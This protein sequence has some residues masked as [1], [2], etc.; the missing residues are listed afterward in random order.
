MS[1]THGEADTE[2]VFS[3]PRF[4]LWHLF[5]LVAWS[6]VA[7][8][9]FK[10]LDA[11]IALTLLVGGTA[12]I[13]SIVARSVQQTVVA[14]GAT[15]LGLML[16]LPELNVSR[17]PSP[18]AQC[19]NNLKQITLALQN[20]EASH[21]AFPPAYIADENGK[22]MHSWRVLI[23]PQLDRND[24]Y[25]RYRFDEPWDGPNNKLLHGEGMDIFVCPSDVH[26]PGVN[27]TSYVAVLGDHTAW[28][29]ATPMTTQSISARDGT[30]RTI[31]LMET[32]N[33]GIHWMEPRDTTL[34]WC[35]NG[36]DGPAA[37]KSPGTQGNHTGGGVVSFVDGHVMY[38]DHSVTGAQLKELLTID[39]NLPSEPE[40]SRIL[41]Q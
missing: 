39:D 31:L 36:I 7:T 27:N 33:S 41:G 34:D 24:L 12:I 14:C 13:A 38:L 20:Y 3:G 11:P 4:Q 1:T 15:L 10:Y 9:L 22:P 37:G 18:R 5:A 25:K 8:A 19:I 35:V 32:H 16:F 21:G 40:W 6:G 28:P 29:G 26:A 17:G 30:S 23:L 2:A